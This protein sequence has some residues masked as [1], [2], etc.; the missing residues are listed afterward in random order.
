VKLWNQEEILFNNMQ[1]MSEQL[2]F[3][4]LQIKNNNKK[5]EKF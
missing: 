5:Q 1:Q 3:S 2:M 4:I